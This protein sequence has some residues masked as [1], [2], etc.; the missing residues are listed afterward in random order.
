MEY[1]CHAWAGVPSCYQFDMLD[2][3]QKQGCRTFGPSKAAS[4]GPLA[5]C[6]IVVTLSLSYWYY[7]DVDVGVH[8]NLL[9]WFH[10]PIPVRL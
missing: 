1:C 6:Q 7:F 2:K 10:F 9:N 4:F 8:L 3:L 5:C